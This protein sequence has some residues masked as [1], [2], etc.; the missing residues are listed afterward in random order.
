MLLK[1]EKRLKDT[2]NIFLFFSADSLEM[3]TEEE[4]D[5]RT[6]LAESITSEARVRFRLFPRLPSLSFGY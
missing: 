2:L 6:D 5:F 3:K 4:M 1:L